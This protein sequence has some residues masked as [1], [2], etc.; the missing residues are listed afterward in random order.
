M[1]TELNYTQLN[2]REDINKFSFKTTDDIEP[3]KGIIG[4]ERAVKAFEFGLNVKMKGYNIYVSGPS[5]SGKTTYAKLSA[6]E[7]AKNE[8]V[9]Y[10]WCYVYNFDDPRSPLS[11]RFEPG[12]GRQFRDDMNELV[13]FF[14]TELT[15]AFTSEDYDK[16]KS[17]L[18]RTYDDKRDELIKKLDSVAS[19]NSFALKT[20]NSGII[21]QPIIDNVLIT[22]ENYDSLDEDVKNGINERLESMQ[23]VVNS[24]MRDIKNI[25]K[26]YRQKMDDL[27]YKIG[28]FAIGHYVSALQE[29]YQYSERVIKYL[30]SV[31]EDVLENIDQ[32]SEQEPDEEDPVAALLPKLGGTKNDDATLKY[33]VN[34][35][36]D[37]SKTEGAPVIVDYNPTYY[38]LVGEVEYDNEY[39]N[40]T[41]DFMKIKPG[42]MHRAN[43]GYLIIQAQDLLS[44]VQ[45][46]EALRR[47]IKTKEIT[48]ENLRDQVGAIAVTTLKPEPIPS[49]VKVILVGGAYYYELLR[50]YDED[51]SK[52]F[53]IRADFDYEMDRNDDNIFKIAGFIS[54]FCENEKTLPFDSSAVASVI[55]YSSRSVESQKKLSTRFNL[56]AEILAES[57]TWAQ[58]DNAEII[59]AEYVKKAEEEKAY[60]LSMYQE[61]M[62]ELLDNNTIMIATDGYCVG[63]INGL[64]V[65]DMGDY[66]FGSP[67]RITATTYMG[68]S[69]IVNIEKEAEMSGPTHNKGVQIITGY[70]GRMYA[71]KMPLSLS[72][73]IAFEQNYNGI[74]G[75]SASSTEL[76]C[77]LSSLS[78][79]P[80]NQ[81]LAVT[82]SVNQCGEIQAIG[83][84]THKIEGYF[85]LCSRRG[86]TGKQ[87]VV[88]PESNVNDL[89][90]KDDVI[91]AV[92][93]GMFHIYSISTID[94]GIE[95]LLGTEAG[96]M[97]E[98]GDYPPESVHGKVMAKLKK[99]NEYNED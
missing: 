92:K 39:G 74:D 22:E 5:G 80:V 57:A 13:S 23:D 50:G 31:Q 42:L 36:V 78:E 89:V 8:A 62:N 98:N 99:F 56:I 91:E 49:D 17:D 41:T 30:E 12:I 40:L 90:L 93:N 66:S 54:K 10:D 97:D 67:T 64:A 32:F 6:K 20:S 53:K 84:V 35:I 77:I 43:G 26:E 51:F 88:I 52:L 70:L 96:V 95:L 18:S 1:K 81:S 71:Q 60:R 68:K 73:R 47:I 83:G 45:A 37:N 86:L 28:M 25:D 69:G 7:K 76:Y 58:L 79:I 59:T 75:D 4:Q 21:F 46:W 29:K 38:N 34:L 9:P 27:D 24:I 65:L 72:C 82:G 3:F 33:R 14:K 2:N 87:G 63:K 11:L 19:E 15:K 85:D 48:I 94:E 16:E 44:N 61:K 55:E